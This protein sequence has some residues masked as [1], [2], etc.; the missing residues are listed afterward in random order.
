MG[1]LFAYL[2]L[3]A[4]SVAVIMAAYYIARKRALRKMGLFQ[5]YVQAHFPDL[6]AG[7][8]LFSAKQESRGMR[9][10]IGLVINDMKKEIIIL[11]SEKGDEIMHKVYAFGDL[12]AVESS[13]TVLARGFLP[14]NYNYEQTMLLKFKDSS[15]YKFIIES[16]SNKQGNDK[17]ANMVR[18]FFTPWEARLNQILK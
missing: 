8:D 13:H 17:G 6:P 7:S 3:W 5:Q 4:G 12:Q 16:F 15:S 2:L 10:N 11:L 9:V 14:K 1:R 18:Q